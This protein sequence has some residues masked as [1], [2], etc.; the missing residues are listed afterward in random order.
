MR[1]QA[2]VFRPWFHTGKQGGASSS[3]TSHVCSWKKLGVK[4]PSENLVI[5]APGSF[6]PSSIPIY[7]RLA[8][9]YKPQLVIA[10]LNGWPFYE[11]EGTPCLRHYQFSVSNW[12][13]FHLLVM[14]V[15]WLRFLYIEPRNGCRNL[16]KHVLT[17]IYMNLSLEVATGTCFTE[18]GVNT[19]W[20]VAQQA[21]HFADLL[22]VWGRQKLYLVSISL[23]CNTGMSPSN[24][25]SWKVLSGLWCY[26]HASINFI[27]SLWKLEG[28]TH[29]RG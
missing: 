9:G 14:R 22:S 10:F 23:S 25:A 26:M 15:Q 28:Q 4:C 19:A 2:C 6:L 7:E 20:I 11:L 29:V 5:L 18:C 24:M 16:W 3:F 1:V 8:V 12:S 13:N 27:A 21:S 17:H